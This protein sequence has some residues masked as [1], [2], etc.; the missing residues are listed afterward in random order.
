MTF[1][2]AH[3]V[4]E[5]LGPTVVPVCCRLV[6]GLSLGP[7]T[8][9]VCRQTVCLVRP[10]VV[11]WPDVLSRAHIPCERGRASD[12]PW[13]S[14]SHIPVPRM[15]KLACIPLERGYGWKPVVGS[16]LHRCCHCHIVV[17][18]S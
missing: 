1:I 13:C 4:D 14:P 18:R 12:G 16:S 3:F 7:M 15:K 17:V 2:M 11:V 8:C 5:P 6:A 9:Q 10:M